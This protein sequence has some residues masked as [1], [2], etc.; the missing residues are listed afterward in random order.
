MLK[1]SL[2][3]EP[4][5]HKPNTFFLKPFVLKHNVTEVCVTSQYNIQ[6]AKKKTKAVSVK[7]HNF[8]KKIS[9]LKN[10]KI[11]VWQN[12]REKWKNTGIWTE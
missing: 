3:C 2:F 9:F 11:S 10:I 5:I 6:R 4:E 12:E 7:L 1:L 8:I